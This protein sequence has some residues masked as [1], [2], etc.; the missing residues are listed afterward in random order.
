MEG[1]A[2]AEQVCRTIG[3][4]IFIEMTHLCCRRCLRLKNVA[5]QLKTRPDT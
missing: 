4:F 3:C 2:K 1:K 5:M